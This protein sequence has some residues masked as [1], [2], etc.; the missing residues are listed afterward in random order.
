MPIFCFTLRY[1]KLINYI[2]ENPYLSHLS[3]LAEET[4]E[5]EY[6]YEVVLKESGKHN[7]HLHGKYEADEMYA[8]NKKKWAGSGYSFD[9]SQIKNMYAWD[10][11]CEKAPYR[12]IDDVRKAIN[13]YE[14]EIITLHTIDQRPRRK[15]RKTKL[16]QDIINLDK[17]SSDDSY[18]DL[19]LN[20][21]M[22]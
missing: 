10:K 2:Y 20:K 6:I 3:R 18:S 17:R 14:K 16:L 4:S 22:F 1:N 9:C 13:A 12:T 21:K 8:C 15:P 7:V 5:L 19:D 11:Y